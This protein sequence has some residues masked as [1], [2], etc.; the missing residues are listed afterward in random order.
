MLKNYSKS[1]SISIQQLSIK[2]YLIS[3][4]TDFS[5][6]LLLIT[7]I[8]TIIIALKQNWNILYLIWIYWFQSVT[9]GLFNFFKLKLLAKQDKVQS[10]FSLH[11]FFALHYGLF[12]FV[13][14][15]FILVFTIFK[16]EFFPNLIQFTLKDFGWMFILSL[17]FFINHLFSYF[18]NK[19]EILSKDIN[20]VMLFPYARIVPMHLTL[21][22]AFFLGSSSLLLFLILKTVMDIIMHGIEHKKRDNK[23]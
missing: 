18:Y 16:E 23:R 6:W 8:S 10:T 3:L 2:S 11:W 21:I 19:E 1:K 15:V 20:Q 7:N 22:L 13:Y 12:H 14:L 4:L 9:I 17:A 5:F